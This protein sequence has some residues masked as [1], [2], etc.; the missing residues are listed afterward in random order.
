V[1]VAP[2]RAGELVQPPHQ[3]I[4][5]VLR[6]ARL[7]LQAPEQA[8][9]QIEPLRRAV[10]Q[11][12]A[13][14]IEERLA[15]PHRRGAWARWRQGVASCA[16]RSP[17]PCPGSSQATASGSIPARTSARAAAPGFAVIGCRQADAHE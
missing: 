2:H 4:G 7:A 17:V 13:H 6:R 16:N 8:I 12:H 3:R 5:R 11:G 15:G 10:E 1:N 14:Q 9:G